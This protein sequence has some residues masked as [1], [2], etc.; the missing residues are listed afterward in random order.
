VAT[1]THFSCGADNLQREQDTAA[2]SQT[3]SGNADSQ[4]I[5]SGAISEE[6]ARK[7]EEKDLLKKGET[8]FYFY[9]R[10]QNVSGISLRKRLPSWSMRLMQL[11]Q[12]L[13]A[14]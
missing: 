11:A 13:L 2:R 8:E 9:K 7:A 5:D 6:I 14:T 10:R 4:R 12:G 3:A 1:N